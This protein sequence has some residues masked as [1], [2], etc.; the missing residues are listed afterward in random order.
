MLWIG[1]EPRSPSRG[2]GRPPCSSRCEGRLLDLS[3]SEE[4]AR[5]DIR[6]AAQAQ[7]EIGEAARAISQARS[8]TSSGFMID[9]RAAETQVAQAEQLLQTQ[10]YEQSI[11]L[12]GAAMQSARQTYYALMQQEFMRRMTMGAER[13]AVRSECRRRLGTGSASAPPRR[14]P[15]PPRSSTG[16]PVHPGRPAQVRADSPDDSGAA[17]GSWSEDAGGGSW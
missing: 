11:Q 4:L 5:E 9:T 16:S 1:S 8:Y 14:P 13:A 12:A 15:R 3:T 2:A 6:L 10:N 7:S 17:V